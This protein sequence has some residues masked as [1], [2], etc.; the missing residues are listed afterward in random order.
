MCRAV[1]L[2]EPPVNIHSYSSWVTGLQDVYPQTVKLFLDKSLAAVYRWLNHICHKAAMCSR[3]WYA[4]FTGAWYSLVV[5]TDCG[6]SLYSVVVKRCFV[7]SWTWPV[8]IGH[9]YGC[10]EHTTSVHTHNMARSV[11]IIWRKG[12]RRDRRGKERMREW[13][14]RKGEGGEWCPLSNGTKNHFYNQMP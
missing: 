3:K 8:F 6:H 10:S 13:E 4:V 9:V 2:H 7:H 12:K 5:F 11:Y 14:R 1:T